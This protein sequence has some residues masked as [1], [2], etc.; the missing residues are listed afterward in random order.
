MGRIAAP[1]RRTLR[2]RGM[3]DNG[4][5]P[6]S[7]AV[8]YSQLRHLDALARRRGSAPTAGLARFR[9]GAD[10]ARSRVGAAAFAAFVAAW[11][12]LDREIEVPRR[13]ARHSGQPLL[14]PNGWVGPGRRARDASKA[15]EAP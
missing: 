14:P 2:A 13:R 6:V 5:T 9:H 7:K 10:P 11:T 4:Q 8:G 3:L 15:R 12:T 1:A